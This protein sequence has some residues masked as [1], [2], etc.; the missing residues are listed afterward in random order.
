MVI[1]GTKLVSVG[2]GVMEEKEDKAS[3]EDVDELVSGGG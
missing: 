2:K 3:E 1:L